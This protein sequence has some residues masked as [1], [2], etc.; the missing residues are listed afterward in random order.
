MRRF[1][2]DDN[3]WEPEA[4]IT[5]CLASYAGWED[6]AHS[7]SRAELIAAAS[8]AHGTPLAHCAPIQTP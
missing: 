7:L 8:Q 3:T 5:G 1:D 4:N 2:D 6:V